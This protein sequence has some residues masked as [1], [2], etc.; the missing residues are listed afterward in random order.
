MPVLIAVMVLLAALVCV[1][2]FQGMTSSF[3]SSISPLMSSASDGDL[4]FVIEK[5]ANRLKS[6]MP[7]PR[8][9]IEAFSL[10]VETI[11]ADSQSTI[12]AVIVANAS[13]IAAITQQM[14]KGAVLKS[15]VNKDPNAPQRTLLSDLSH[16]MDT[17]DKASLFSPEKLLLGRK[18]LGE[19]GKKQDRSSKHG[20]VLE[21]SPIESSHSSPSHEARSPSAER[22][23]TVR[24]QAAPAVR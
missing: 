9:E 11:I 8:Y 7:L 2:S 20:V 6:G 12:P 1:S 13:P 16:P 18:E 19:G 24:R 3:T 23:E 15:A 5:L 17:A 14:E 21:R 22:S 10:A 4:N